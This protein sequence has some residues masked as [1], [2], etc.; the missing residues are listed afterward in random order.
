MYISSFFVTN[1][2]DFVFIPKVFSKHAD[3]DIVRG[4]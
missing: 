3:I 4:K 1:C 2:N